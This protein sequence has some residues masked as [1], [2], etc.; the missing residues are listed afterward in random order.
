MRLR[1]LQ[2]APFEGPA[3][4]ERWAA[5]RGHEAAGTRLDQGEPLPDPDAFDLLV[6]LGGPMGA[7]ETE[8][9]G[10]L[11]PEREL[12]AETVDRGTPV[13]GICL[14]AQL[15]A[16]ALGAD[17]YPGET[18]EQGWHSVEAVDPAG[19]P[20]AA[21]PDR[22]AAFHWHGD[23]FDLPDGARRLARTDACE[24]QAF[25][26]GNALGLQFHLEVTP[27][28]VRALVAAAGDPSGPYAGDPLAGD[29]EALYGRLAATLDRLAE[30]ASE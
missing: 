12:I 7:Y 14:G 1:Y 4:V 29:F 25:A 27:G 18:V 24:N 11:G 20:L 30:T 3:N 28:S 17:V 15:L 23:T 6:V 21:L 2:H 16:A 8:E 13:L 19:S 22:Y 10:W 5:E 26:L 9:H